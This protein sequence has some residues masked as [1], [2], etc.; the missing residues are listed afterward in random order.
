[1]Q[2]TNISFSVL[3]VH[4]SSS[5]SAS[6][7]LFSACSLNKGGNMSI[8]FRST[9]ADLEPVCFVQIAAQSKVT[10]GFM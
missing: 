2:A 8:Q 3:K 10:N 7:N 4:F 6:L 1:M 9:L 5:H